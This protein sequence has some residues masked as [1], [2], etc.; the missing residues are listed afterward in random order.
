M[1]TFVE[2]DALAKILVLGI[3]IGGG[4][5]VLFAVAV[6]ALH[7][8]GEHAVARSHA[9]WRKALAI[10]CFVVAAVVVGG[11]IAYI[12]AGGH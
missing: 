6:R 7:P 11:G 8:H 1:S 3:V 5:P 4:L 12:A 2:W 9:W 10:S